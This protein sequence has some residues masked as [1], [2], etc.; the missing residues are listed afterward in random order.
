MDTRSPATLRSFLQKRCNRP[1][2][3]SCCLVMAAS[4]AFLFATAATGD[5]PFADVTDARVL[6][7]P[8]QFLE[9][10]TRTE[11]VRRFTLVADRRV[12]GGGATITV[13]SDAGSRR[14]EAAPPQLSL[15]SG[16]APPT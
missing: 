14:H 8:P 3:T 13:L 6:G 12:F 1:L 16:Q 11:A 10:R 5:F 15:F 7:E 2:Q 4:L 9:V